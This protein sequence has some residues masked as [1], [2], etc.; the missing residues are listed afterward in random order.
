MQVTLYPTQPGPYPQ[1]VPLG[2]FP[3]ICWHPAV[4]DPLHASGTVHQTDA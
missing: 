2:E 4:L 1:S 3:H